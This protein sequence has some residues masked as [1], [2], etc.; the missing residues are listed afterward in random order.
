MDK[1]INLNKSCFITG[2][3]GTGK[4]ELI[5]ILKKRWLLIRKLIERF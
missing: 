4:T 5:R 2:P 1:V 3:A